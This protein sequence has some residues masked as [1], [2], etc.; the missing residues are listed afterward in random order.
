MKSLLKLA[1][2]A[3]IAGAVVSLLAK[4]WSR[5]RSEDALLTASAAKAGKGKAGFTVGELLTATHVGD[6]EMTRPY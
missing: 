2:G 1:M 3:A 5:S 6:E 4:Q